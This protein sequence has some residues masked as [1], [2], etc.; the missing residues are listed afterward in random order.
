MTQQ[1]SVYSSRA[2]SFNFQH[3]QQADQS[4]TPALRDPTSGLLGFLGSCVYI[5]IEKHTQL[6]SIL[7]KSSY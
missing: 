2:P 1:L 5:H 6:K 4:V 3:P 7:I